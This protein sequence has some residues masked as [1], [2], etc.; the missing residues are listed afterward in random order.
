MSELEQSLQAFQNLTEHMLLFLPDTVGDSET[1]LLME[2]EQ[3]ESVMCLEY[4]PYRCF[5]LFWDVMWVT[6]EAYGSSA[7][8]LWTLGT[9]G[10]VVPQANS[11]VFWDSNF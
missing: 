1:L 3:P 4:E 2:A 10:Q 8:K 5:A 11:F 7:L 9:T 6:W